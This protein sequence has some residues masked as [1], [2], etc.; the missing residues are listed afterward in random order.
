MRCYIIHQR[1][2]EEPS[3]TL[4]SALSS[5]MKKLVDCP[6]IQKDLRILLYL[7]V[8]QV[9][10]LY[11][12]VLHSKEVLLKAIECAKMKVDLIGK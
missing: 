5:I 11:G 12:H 6:P 4:N 9:Y 1:V 10:I 8:A 7:E 3:P 2:L